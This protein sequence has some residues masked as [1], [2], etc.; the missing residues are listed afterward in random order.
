MFSDWEVYYYSYLRLIS[1]YIMVV[2]KY[3]KAKFEKKRKAD[4]NLP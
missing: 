2:E 3:T 4:F 1:V